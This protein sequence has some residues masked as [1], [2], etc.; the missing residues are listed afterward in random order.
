[1]ATQLIIYQRMYELTL[2]LYPM[3]NRIPKSHRSILG[4]Q[5]EE[6]AIDMVLNVLKAN[7]AQGKERLRLQHLLS[8]ELDTLR[9]MV[10][11]CK[12]LKFISIKQYTY[13]SEKM[14][15]IGRMLNS[16]MKIKVE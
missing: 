9:I 3:V 2:W 7:K 13:A 15:E 4:K 6:C 10:R 12:D 16:W 14:N 11:L 8:Y 1:M 5:I